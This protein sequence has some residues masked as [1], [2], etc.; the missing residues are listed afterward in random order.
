MRLSLDDGGGHNLIRSYARGRITIN[1]ITITRSVVL[2]P[3]AILDD[4]APESFEDLCAADME[5]TLALEPEMVLL[6]TGARQQF[7]PAP[8]LAPLLVRGIGVEI[9]DTAAACRT[10]NIVM[11][12]GRRVVAA[13]LMI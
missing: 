9:M 2:S 12:E 5:R 4:W 3:D 10:Y 11:A 1:D 6:G 7:P 13:L 8:V